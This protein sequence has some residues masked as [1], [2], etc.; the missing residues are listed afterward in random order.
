MADTC[1][2]FSWT[3]KHIKLGLAFF[4]TLPHDQFPR[5]M[6]IVSTFANRT[7]VISIV[8]KFI[9]CTYLRIKC[10]RQL[11]SGSRRLHSCTCNDAG[12]TWLDLSR[13]LVYLLLRLSRYCLQACHVYAVSS[14]PLYPAWELDSGHTGHHTSRCTYVHCRYI[15]EILDAVSLSLSQWHLT[16]HNTSIVEQ[17]F[18]IQL[19]PSCLNRSHWPRVTA[20][21]KVRLWTRWTS[22][23]CRD[24]GYL[25]FRRLPMACKQP[26]G[27]AK[28]VAV[29]V[30]KLQEDRDSHLGMCT[31]LTSES[32]RA[33]ILAPLHGNNEI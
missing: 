27:I 11:S 28:R 24:D 22:A 30:T 4:D 13:M 16:F 10:K 25:D 9:T 8:S 29:S 20:W 12:L 17:V 19:C 1:E 14:T 23:Q 3:V 18:V 32:R 7:I 33:P 31:G 5:R 6:S 2:R 26:G 15:V 21:L